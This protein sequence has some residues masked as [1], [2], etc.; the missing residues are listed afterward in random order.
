MSKIRISLEKISENYLDLKACLL[1]KKIDIT[2]VVKVIAGDNRIAE[3]FEKNGADVIADSRIENIKK[4]KKSGIKSKILLLRLPSK[5][6]ISEV[7]EFSDF[8]L[9]SSLEVIS[10]IDE[11]AKKQK[12]RHGIVL[13]I[14]MG[15]LREGVNPDKALGISKKISEMENVYLKGIGSN[16][17]CYG[18]IVPSAQ[19]MQI[20][21]C[22]SKS[23]P[24]IDWVSGGNSANI[25][26]A[27]SSKSMY[28]IN[29]LRLG[30][31]IMLGRETLLR[32][33]IPE[34]NL[35]AF[36]LTSEV[37]ESERKNSLPD[38]EIAQNAFGEIPTFKDEGL[39]NR[40]ILDIGRQDID[41]KGLTPLD[42]GI[43]ILGASS[44]HLIIK[45][46]SL[47]KVGDTVEFIPS[48]SSL[49]RAMSSPHVK[50][51]Y[52]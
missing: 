52:L 11:E 14:E 23:F 18:G 7:V 51:V 33:P 47:I 28:K 35:D 37:I 44:D 48:Y 20:L 24:G 43:E 49:L 10:M 4:F 21:S 5:S 36:V 46:N 32:K 38:G 42:K 3:V 29:H 50:K 26:W 8:S 6:G 16:F 39:I 1:K 40:A 25:S 19:K 17:A 22:I 34:L 30:E 27:R 9:N 31:S 12:K 2:P 41:P 45:S 13:M 15:D